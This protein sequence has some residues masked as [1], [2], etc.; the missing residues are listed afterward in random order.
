[1]EMLEGRVA[2][3]GAACGRH[4]SGEHPTGCLCDLPDDLDAHRAFRSDRRNP[5]PVGATGIRVAA[6]GMLKEPT[7]PG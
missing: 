2:S 3:T 6:G 4:R 1:M 5:T 7:A